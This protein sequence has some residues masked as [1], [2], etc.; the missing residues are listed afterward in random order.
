MAVDLAPELMDSGRR[1]HIYASC[2]QRAIATAAALHKRCN[3]LAP[4]RLD[5]HLHIRSARQTGQTG[6]HARTLACTQQT[7]MSISK[8]V[9]CTILHRT[10]LYENDGIY[11]SARSSPGGDLVK[12]PGKAKDRNKLSALGTALG[13]CQFAINHCLC[14][15]VRLT[16]L[17]VFVLFIFSVRRRLV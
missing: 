15:C 12:V 6:A 1:I 11:A 3:E 9:S 5:P 16:A 17:L 8:S 7:E 2:M 14:Y 4:T 13:V 10:D